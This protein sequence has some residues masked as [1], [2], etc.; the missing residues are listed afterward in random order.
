MYLEKLR[1]KNNRTKNKYLKKYWAKNK[2]NKI[3]TNCSL[4]KYKRLTSNKIN[5]MFV[6]SKNKRKKNI[7][8]DAGH[9]L[10]KEIDSKDFEN[11]NLTTKIRRNKEAKPYFLKNFSKRSSN[12]PNHKLK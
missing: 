7:P 4:S 9:F 8:S 2:S 11:E 10:R 6:L 5:Y 3:A 1:Q 12:R